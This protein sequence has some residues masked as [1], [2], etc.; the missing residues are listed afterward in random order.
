MKDPVQ[1][2][3]MEALIIFVVATAAVVLFAYITA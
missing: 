1:S 3:G 2:A